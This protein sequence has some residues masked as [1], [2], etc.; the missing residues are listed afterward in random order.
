MIIDIDRIQYMLNNNYNMCTYLF[1]VS[2]RNK[3]GPKAPGKEEI[4]E[5]YT[6]LQCLES[7]SLVMMQCSWKHVTLDKNNLCQF[8]S[9]TKLTSQNYWNV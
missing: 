5:W 6:S 7:R 8:F 3:A 1:W 9:N 4:C 2:D